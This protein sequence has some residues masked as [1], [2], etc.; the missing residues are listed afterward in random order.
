MEFRQFLLNELR[1]HKLDKRPT[2]FIAFRGDLWLFEDLSDEEIEEIHRTIVSNHPEG[3]DLPDYTV[4]DQHDLMQWVQ[5]TILDS[6]V[7]SWDS[8]RR[9]IFTNTEIGPSPTSSPLIKKVVDALGARS[10]RHETQ[11]MYGDDDW[12]WRNIKYTKKQIRGE[13]PDNMYHGTSTEY[14]PGIFKLGLAPGESQTNYPTIVHHYDKVFLTAKFE[15]ALYHAIHTSG[16]VGGFPTVLEFKVPDKNLL[17]PD[18]DADVS[19]IGSDPMYPGSNDKRS[20]AS[21]GPMKASKHAG[22]FGYWGTI[23]VRNLKSVYLRTERVVYGP[24]GAAEGQ[25]N[26][27][28]VRIDTLKKRMNEDPWDWPHYY[29]LWE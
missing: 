1:I 24:T 18:Y 21:V 10:I 27:R 19:A 23:P 3:K 22:L 29:G 15:E 26:F 20:W 17:V 13:I 8:R 2:D 11:V 6:F 14:L 25:K 7:G 28:K 9:V 5:E 12:E 16:K 4:R